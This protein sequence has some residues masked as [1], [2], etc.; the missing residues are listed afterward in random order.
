MKNLIQILPIACLLFGSCSGGAESDSPS[1]QA[2]L[3]ISLTDAPVDDLT[4]FVVDIEAITLTK[5]GGGVVGALPSTATVDLV[6]LVEVS[7]VLSVL[8]V[9]PGFYD[10]ATVTLDFTNASASLVGSSTPATLVDSD[11]LPLDGLVTLP[12]TIGNAFSAAAGAHR[13]LELDFDLN[14][15]VVV[16]LPGNQISMEPVI[17]MR[18]DRSDPKTFALTGALRSVDSANSSMVVQLQTLNQAPLR[19]AT[20]FVDSQTLYQIDGLAVVGA[21][22][23][24]DLAALGTGAWVQLYGTVDIFAGRIDA[25]YV[26]AGTG[27][28]NGGTDIVEG[29]VVER[30]GGAGIDPVLTVLGFSDDQS[31][32]SF[33]FNTFFMVTGDFSDTRVVRRASAAS[34]DTDDLNIGQHVRVFGSLS[35][36]SLNAISGVI[37]MLPTRLR[38]YANVD[39]QSSDLDLDLVRVGHRLQS[40]FSWTDGGVTPPDPVHLDVEVGNLGSGLGVD[41]SSAVE[42]VGFFSPVDDGGADF[43]ATSLVNLDAAP[44]LLAIQNR[45]GGFTLETQAGPGAISME[46][47]GAPAPFEFAHIDK[48]F[49]GVLPLPATPSPQIVPAGLFGLYFLRDRV[50]GAVRLD[51]NFANFSS[52]LDGF[53]GLGAQVR[54]LGALGQYSQASNTMNAGIV[55]V[56]VE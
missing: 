26:E 20:V 53:L 47:F 12:I 39:L 44:S 46:I 31:H 48:G 28:Y 11:G 34:F 55:V 23:L 29:Y 51:L 17:V 24:T 5:V 37:R 38:G 3:T 6:S 30:L 32:T 14:Q 33:Q 27:T 42:V 18:V 49:V 22:G 15:S 9:P 7:Q 43:L 16:D 35:G 8:N 4:S 21:G 1:E 25:S 50:T 56:V 54:Q 40:E 52:N 36:Q 13:I 19:D 10:R 2:T 41:A 45:P